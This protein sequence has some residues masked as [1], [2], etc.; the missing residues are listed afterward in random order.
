LNAVYRYIFLM[1]LPY[2]NLVLLNTAADL[3]NYSSDVAIVTE[4]H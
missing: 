3:K 2:Q 4:T 1:P